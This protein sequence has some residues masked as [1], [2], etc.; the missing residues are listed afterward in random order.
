MVYQMLILQNQNAIVKWE[1]NGSI[2]KRMQMRGE[3]KEPIKK[4]CEWK[5]NWD[6]YTTKK[7]TNTNEITNEKNQSV[8]LGDIYRPNWFHC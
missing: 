3:K 8:F 4:G 7:S 6:G 1:Q 2:K 5:T